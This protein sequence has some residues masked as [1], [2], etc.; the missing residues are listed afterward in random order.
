MIKNAREQDLA[1]ITRLEN[2]IWPEGTRA[3]QDKFESRLKIFPEGFFLA[4]KNEELIGV[5]TSEIIS[6]DA[7][8]P[9][10]SWEHITSNGYIRKMHNPNGNAIYV[11]SIGAKS[12]S[13]GG[14]AL[15]QAQKNL[16]EKLKLKFLVL[17]ARIPGYNDYINQNK[18]IPIEEYVQLKRED[19]Q[20]FDSELRFYTRNGLNLIKIM[21]NYMEDDK[22]SRNF[23]AIMAWH[24]E[25]NNKY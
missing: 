23:G 16:T 5:S 6:Y 24:N 7:S 19:N 9:P 20:L 4:Y 14:S 8:N 13:G 12:R 25:N 10:K 22:E 1:E 15:I 18:E 2:E 17:G 3:T 21:P 11:V